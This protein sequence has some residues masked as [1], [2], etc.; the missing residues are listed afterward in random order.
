MARRRT[1]T[2]K[3]TLTFPEGVTEQEVRQ[4]LDEVVAAATKR[5][6]QVEAN[7]AW[8]PR[9]P[10]REQFSLGVAMPAEADSEPV[11]K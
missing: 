7:V 3:I 5:Q 9:P 6:G 10:V 1:T 8:P 2:A 4:A 11:A